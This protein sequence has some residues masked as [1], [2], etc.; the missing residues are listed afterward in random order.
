[1]EKEQQDLL[2]KINQK[3][4][5]IKSGRDY[6]EVIDGSVKRNGPEYRD[7]KSTNRLL[8]DQANRKIDLYQLLS[9]EDNLQLWQDNAP[10]NIK[11]VLFELIHS[12]S[13]A[14]STREKNALSVQEPKPIQHGFHVTPP[15]E[16]ISHVLNQYKDEHFVDIQ[17]KIKPFI[18]FEGYKHIKV[19]EKAAQVLKVMDSDWDHK[20]AFFKILVEHFGDNFDQVKSD[21]SQAIVKKEI[22]LAQDG[23]VLFHTRLLNKDQ[24]IQLHINEKNEVT[25]LSFIPELKNS[26]QNI[27]DKA[28]NNSNTKTIEKK[29]S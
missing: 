11:N 27:R 8:R 29:L 6:L 18:E 12:N 19:Q 9:N 3:I 22:T 2:K 17:N 15:L 14:V 25:G 10:L 13:L 7:E 4:E 5:G 23:S 20:Q 26:I 28:F 1:M 24:K 16:N 21:F